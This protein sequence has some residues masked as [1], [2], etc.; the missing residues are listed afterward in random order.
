MRRGG[1]SF[2]HR[3]ALFRFAVYIYVPGAHTLAAHGIVSARSGH[4]TLLRAMITRTGCPCQ[5][6]LARHLWLMNFV[7][8]RRRSSA[9]GGATGGEEY[10]SGDDS[11]IASEDDEDEEMPD[12][13]NPLL[14]SV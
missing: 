12:G 8:S 13:E 5:H 11:F 2:L 6:F 3:Q 10:D 1:A 4:H 7:S 14:T 9:V